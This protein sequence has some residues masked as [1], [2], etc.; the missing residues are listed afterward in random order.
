MGRDVKSGKNPSSLG[1]CYFSSGEEFSLTKNK[2]IEVGE[3]MR[4]SSKQNKS[5]K[6]WDVIHH[7]SIITRSTSLGVAKAGN[8]KLDFM[9]KSIGIHFL[10]LEYTFRCY[11]DNEKLLLKPKTTF[12]RMDTLKN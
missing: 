7:Q 10:G 9:A 11:I 2:Q 8:L 6:L 1:N 4:S 3:A 12:G 5:K